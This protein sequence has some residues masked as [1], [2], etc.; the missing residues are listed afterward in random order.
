M[1]HLKEVGAND[2]GGISAFA[3]LIAALVAARPA[4]AAAAAA[5]AQN[6]PQSNTIQLDYSQT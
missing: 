4:A 5:V 1:N 3:Y 2:R 6:A